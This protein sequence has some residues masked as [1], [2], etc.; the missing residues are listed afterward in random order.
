MDREDEPAPPLPVEE[1][2]E[3]G[4]MATMFSVAVASHLHWEIEKFLRS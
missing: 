2:F 3:G 4:R 1:L